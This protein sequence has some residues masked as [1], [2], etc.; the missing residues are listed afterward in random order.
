M[1]TMHTTVLLYH[2]IL[3]SPFVLV[4]LAKAWMA[5]TSCKYYLYKV[6]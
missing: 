4:I 3:D 6:F 5:A 2:Q 1:Q